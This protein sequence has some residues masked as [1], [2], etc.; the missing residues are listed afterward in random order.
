MATQSSGR[1]IV[2]MAI[3]ALAAPGASMLAER[4]SGTQLQ[5]VQ[6]TCT[7]ASNA[8]RGPSRSCMRVIRAPSRECWVYLVEEAGERVRICHVERAAHV[9][10]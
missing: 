2:V 7:R 4:G 10:P 9:E 8:L 3:A 5:G 6:V 1:F